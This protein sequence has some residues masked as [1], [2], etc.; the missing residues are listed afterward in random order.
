MFYSF[1]LFIYFLVSL[2]LEGVEKTR[3]N[4]EQQTKEVRTA[5]EEKLKTAAAQR[6]E[7]IKKMLDRLKEHVSVLLLYFFIFI[8]NTQLS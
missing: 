3:L 6:D 4:L 7:N 1:I 8:L 2:Q 5:V